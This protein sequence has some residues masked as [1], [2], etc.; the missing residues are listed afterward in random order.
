MLVQVVSYNQV[1]C[2]PDSVGLH[3]MRGPVIEVAQLGIVEI[4]DLCLT[5]VSKSHAFAVLW[6]ELWTGQLKGC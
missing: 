3:G 5:K 4:R 1:M 6:V 2:H